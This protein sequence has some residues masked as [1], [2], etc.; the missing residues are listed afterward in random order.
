MV[1]TTSIAAYQGAPEAK[2]RAA[3]CQMVKFG[4]AQPATAGLYANN[5]KSQWDRFYQLDSWLTPRPWIEG[6]FSELHLTC[7]LWHSQWLAPRLPLSN[8]L[9]LPDQ[10]V[11]ERCVQH[12]ERS[13][14]RPIFPVLDPALFEGTIELAYQQQET[15]EKTLAARASVLAFLIFAQLLEVGRPLAAVADTTQAIHT[16]QA[17]LPLIVH[18]RSADAIQTCVMLLST[19]FF[20][21]QLNSAAVT[22]S[23]A[24][25]LLVSFGGHMERVPFESSGRPDELSIHRHIRNLFWV[26]YTIDKELSFRLRQ[27][28]ALTD[29]YC[30]LTLSPEYLD[31]LSVDLAPSIPTAGLPPH[32]FFPSDIR[33]SQI[34]SRV[35]KLLYS[36]ASLEKSAADLVSTIRMLDHDLETWRLSL[37]PDHRPDLSLPCGA[38]CPA[39]P[40]EIRALIVQLEYYHCLTVVHQATSRCGAWALGPEGIPAGIATSIALAVEASRSTLRYLKSAEYVLNVSGFRLILFYPVAASIMLFCNILQNPEAPLAR[41]DQDLITQFPCLECDHLLPQ[42]NT[43]ELLHVAHLKS[44]FRAMGHIA[45]CAILDASLSDL[46]IDWGSIESG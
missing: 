40:L 10:R 17:W 16:V 1:L 39:K 11:V 31:A 33:L 9:D 30:D 42:L 12:F 4:E 36:A 14:I 45:L 26:T 8:A 24:A 46:E 20:T 23:I 3:T 18:A 5:R 41:Q 37:P 15:Q 25:N 6:Q 32:N 35:F 22:N 43:T 34:K 29:D 2:P 21:G 28:P 19:Q 38:S 27:P 44:F 13:S 7:P